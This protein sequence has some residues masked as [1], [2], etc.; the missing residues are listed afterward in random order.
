[1]TTLVLM[2]HGVGG[3][4][5]GMGGLARHLAAPGLVFR[6]PDAPHP[7]NAGFRWFD[8]AGITPQNR[9]ARVEAARKGLDA[10]IDLHQA[11]TGAR[12]VI[13][14]GFS[15]GAIMSIDALAR[16][17]VAEAVIFAG[18]YAVAGAPQPLPGARGLLVGGSF[19]HV[20]PAAEVAEASELL[21]RIGVATTYLEEPIGHEI[22]PSGL[23]AAKTFLQ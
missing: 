9:P 15:Q 4:G 16:G 23:A 14:L 18:R 21:A 3:N 12:R 17:R 11:E 2:L 6:A 8:I 20:I 7:F 13:L 10:L 19:D 22:G 5:A 1:M